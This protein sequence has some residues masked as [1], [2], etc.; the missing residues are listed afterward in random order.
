MLREKRVPSGPR[1]EFSPS[2][3]PENYDPGARAR[4][5]TVREPTRH[6]SSR[7]T[8]S[9]F[10]FGGQADDNLGG[11]YEFLPSPSFD[12]L[13]TSINSS[14]DLDFDRP[15]TMASSVT[16]GNRTKGAMSTSTAPTEVR[17]NSTSRRPPTAPRPTRAGSI[18][19]RQ[20]TSA[21]Q[22]SVSSTSSAATGSM[23]PPSLPLAARTRRQSQYPPISGS[24]MASAARAPRKSTGSGVTESDSART[25]QR[26]RPS[27]APSVSPHGLSDSGGASTRVNIGGAPTYMDGARGLT[28]SRAAK[29]KSLQPPSRQGQTHLSAKAATPD[30]SRSSSFAGR[31]PG[32]PNGRGSSTP[33][34]TAKRMSAMPGMTPSS[35]HATG[36]GARTVSPTDAR[37]AK[38]LSVLQ[39][40]P[41][42]PNTP[43]TPQT[44]TST[45]RTSSR[46]PSMLPRKAST[47]S[48]SRTTPDPNRKSYS[49]GL[50]NA[51]IQSHNTSRTST[52]SLQPRMSLPPS[53][54]RLPTPKPRSTHS[55]AGNN[56]EEEVPPVP[57]IPKAYESPKE[58]PAEQPFFNKRKSS[59]PFDASS[60]N[61][62][63]TN[64]LSGRASFRDLPRN[65]R[66]QK[67]QKCCPASTS[68]DQQNSATLAKKK[69]LQPL[70]LPPL[71]LLPLS[72]PTTAKIAALEKDP[73]SADRLTTPPPRRLNSRTP[74][75]PM[76][77][78]KASVVP[79][80]RDE[81]RVG[82][83]PAYARRSS[84]IH[85]L[86]PESSSQIGEGFE[87]SKPIPMSSR[88]TRQ[89]VSP[90]ISSSLPKSGDEQSFMPRSKT[91]GDVSA[92]E[93]I[94]T[95]PHRPAR[96]TGPRAQQLARPAKIE[97]PSTISSPEEPTTPSSATSLRRKLSLGWK[98]NTSKN[99]VNTSSHAAN[100]RK[101]EQAPQPPKHNKMPP[102]RVPTSA[103]LSL[104][105]NHSVPS[106]SPSVKST[107]YLDSKRRKSSISHPTA[108]GVHDRTRSDPW[109]L[110]VSPKKEQSAA[111][112]DRGPPSARYTSSVVQKML[113]SK[114]SGN[115]IKATDRWTADLD[116]DDMAAEGEVKRLGLKR[117][118]TEQAAA[119]LDALYQRATPKDYM[120][121]QLALQKSKLN[122]FE[123]GE[124]IDYK[125]IYFTG[126]ETA[127]KHVGELAVDTA[128]FGYDDERGDYSIVPGD[129]LSYRYEIVDVLGKGSFGQVVRCV[130]HKNGGLVA[131]KI[132]RNKKRFHQQALVEVNILQKLREWDPKNRHSMV[133]FTQS[134]YFRGHLCIS[135]ELLDMNLY[136]FI[137]SN[138]FKG[139]NLKI[140]RRFTKQILSS[141][142]LLKQHKV[143]HC[144]LKPENVLLA[145]PL[146]SEIKVI[147]FGSSCF[148]NEKVYTYIQSRFYR[149]PEV[150]LGM[151]YGMPIDM[152]SLGCIL[153]EL[154]TGVPIFP[155]ENEQE[156]L[157]CIM[158]VFGPPGKHLIDK[159]TRKKLF[160]DSMGK[161]RLTVSSKGRRRRPSSKSL[162]QVLKCND[163]AF[164]DFLMRCLRW[165]PDTRMKPEEAIRH[166]FLSGQKTTAPFARTAARNDSPIKRNT[167]LTTPS[168]SNR[169]LPEPPATSFKNNTAVRSREP[170]GA[171]PNKTAVPGRRQSTVSGFS[172]T[173]AN[174]RTSTGP[175]LAP[176][177]SG[178]PRVTRSTSGTLPTGMASAGA[179]AAMNRR[180]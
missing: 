68:D 166:E 76:T 94:V 25:A 89:A 113:T 60:I 40:P 56:E 62:T 156:Q 106:P 164:L 107:T 97:T 121:P 100:E 63:S 43:P 155:G 11:S 90:F 51:S 15:S 37:R 116:K 70:R 14:N 131:V 18:V 160:F 110:G 55:S 117:K 130:D 7:N 30:H 82:E 153:A 3:A 173:A 41:P 20:S 112:G 109:G 31:S 108:F 101:P 170:S 96:L 158:E 6:A 126:T 161:P 122:I 36:L 129:H 163:E 118:D 141:L 136:E 125:E 66:E 134:F 105:N 120:S 143:I 49:S 1:P 146:H 13:Q 85:A 75:T 27:L 64:S 168:G 44:E 176:G 8:L 54:S 32:R 152:W 22:S 169:P 34:S 154:Y 177:N 175:A 95:E 93:S 80:K 103:A 77:A 4:A 174:T 165:D 67:P 26:R 102:P 71:N 47:P 24:A 42:M 73:A 38:R 137:K 178:L 83:Q 92:Q 171:S 5:S 150:I 124:I 52:G 53:S 28:A 46:S 88:Q 104:L 151:T 2:K 111:P 59:M 84:S 21:R 132:I 74:T 144:D 19:R 87:S 78:S 81:S 33:S 149:S 180:V 162:D 17:S 127:A 29:T 115:T 142:L 50:S 172:T 23:E 99:N 35:S 79:R 148:E 10:S 119:T 123:R 12:D 140:V 98:R 61:S 138:G 58:S 167:I 135:T 128:N 159:S 147:D 9:L 179:S 139:F 114:S 65:D 157:A 16:G 45:I 72:T 133:N 48:S 91:C 145:H 86:R 39:K 69:S 57:A